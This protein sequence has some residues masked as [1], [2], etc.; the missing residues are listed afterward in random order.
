MFQ[1]NLSDSLTKGLDTLSHS[2]LSSLVLHLHYPLADPA[3]EPQ[4]SR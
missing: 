2:V 4:L 1:Y 3:A